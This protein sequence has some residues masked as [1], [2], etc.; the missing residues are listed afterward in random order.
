M[1]EKFKVLVINPGSTSTK[2]ALFE[3][4]ELLLEKEIPHS[5]EELKPYKKVY[6]EK[7]FRVKLIRQFMDESKVT[8]D[9]LTAIAARGGVVKPIAG[10]AA[11]RVNEKMVN[12]LKE[13]KYGEH[14]SNLGA[15]IANELVKDTD[16][17]AYI[18]DPVVV[19]EMFPLARYSGHPDFP[20]LSILHAL[21]QKAAARKYAASVNK[22]YQ[23]VNLIVTHLGGGISVGAHRKGMV[24][25]VNNALNGDG[26]FTPERSGGL[27]AYQLVEACFSGKYTKDELKKMI[28]GKGGCVAYLGTNDLRVVEEKAEAGDKEYYDVYEAMAYQVSKEI[29]FLIPAFQGEKIDAIVLTG[30]A[31]RSDFLV[32]R[33]KKWT[34]QCKIDLQIFPGEFEMTAL[35]DGALRVLSGEDEE[36]VYD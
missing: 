21:N 28:K 19:D 6:D 33:I 36:L 13:A 10:G 35:R 20:R 18:L 7:D 24:V 8:V 30:G 14:A 12:D 5:T 9:S 4:E 26:P 16:V 3:N 15:I 17:P 27:P 2:L 34:G 22:K 11:Y 1:S 25:D 31:A 32:D 23:D 29:C